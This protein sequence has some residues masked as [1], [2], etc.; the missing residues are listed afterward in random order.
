MTLLSFLSE[1]LQ[2]NITP[3]DDFE[4]DNL[5]AQPRNRREAKLS[6][7]PDE[8]ETYDATMETNKFESNGYY[9]VKLIG[10]RRLLQQRRR[11][12]SSDYSD[13]VESSLLSVINQSECQS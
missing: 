3:E 2:E 6:Q 8:T 7:E 12:S 11:R 13:T 9:T 5:E 1:S 10:E 4:E